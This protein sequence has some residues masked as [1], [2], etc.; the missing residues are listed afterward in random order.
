MP[1]K[2]D[3]PDRDRWLDRARSVAAFRRALLRWYARAARDLPWR[4]TRDPYRIWVSEVLLQQTRVEA[5]RRYYE[6]FLRA[7]PNV[8]AL[9]EAPLGRVLKLWEGL[10][11]YSRARRLHAAA[12]QIMHQ[13][14]G[15]LPR[16]SPQWARLPGVGRYTAA[17]I[18]S[19]AFGE[20]VPAVDGNVK[21][22]L[23]R[24]LR[25][26]EPIG[27]RA[28]EESI[29]RAAARLL[30]RTRPGTFNQA[31]MELGACVCLPRK[32]RCSVCPVARWCA[33]RAAGC[34]CSLP[35]R[36]PRAV[37]PL[38]EAVAAVV[39]YHG[40]Y[41]LVR[42]ER[43]LLAGMW[44]WPSEALPDGRPDETAVQ[45]ALVTAVHRADPTIRISPGQPVDTVEHAFSH[46]R[47]RLHVYRCEVL[48]AADRT[49]PVRHRRR[50]AQPQGGVLSG[51]SGRRSCRNATNAR[52]VR[53][54]DFHRY[55]LAR[56]DQKVLAR[57]A[58]DGHRSGTRRSRRPANR[59]PG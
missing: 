2:R 48:N 25:I 49:H 26:E 6:R 17:A 8:R 14:A 37:A 18:A 36:T 23:A 32:P 46:R 4:R 53:E 58:R 43:G 59:L 10:G 31:L 39:A 16:A 19:I 9:A 34:E 57:L 55:A 52:W 35:R 40:R 12:R 1:A 5:G 20:P 11:Y 15:R 33:A 30:S 54:A 47:L 28:T 22:V 45:A 56:V 7:F 50:A 27:Q 21:R 3:V 38:V 41:L 13:H 42:R 44:G 24:L 29:H 51:A